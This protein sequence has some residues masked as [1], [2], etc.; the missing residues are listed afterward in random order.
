MYLFCAKKIF[1][2]R[3]IFLS[4]LFTDA[5]EC[6]QQWQVDEREPE[7][8]PGR[9]AVA[10]PV[11]PP[12]QVGQVEVE[13]QRVRRERPRRDVKQRRGGADGDRGDRVAEG[14]PAAQV[15]VGDRHHPVAGLG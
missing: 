6:D 3:I 1:L 5:H 9:V 13:R 12:G 11:E 14:D 15:G 2:V 8:F 7:Q 4:P 10:L